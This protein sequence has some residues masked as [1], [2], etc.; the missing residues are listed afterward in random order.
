MSKAFDRSL[1]IANGKPFL[2]RF[3]YI[4]STNSDIASSVEYSAL[5]PVLGGG[6]Y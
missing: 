2:S 6:A 5:K 1:N 4:L 3:K